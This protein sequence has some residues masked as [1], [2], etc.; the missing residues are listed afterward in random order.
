MNNAPIGIL[1]SGVG[2]LTVWREI[3]K[4]LPFESTFYIGDSANSLYGSKSRDQI[5]E[6]ASKMINF[7]VQKDVKLIVIACNTITV[8]CLDQLRLEFPHMPLI[9][10]VPVVKT[11]S[12]KTKNGKIGILSTTATAQS[13]YQK[14]LMKRFASGC[15]VLNIGTDELVPIIEQRAKIKNQKVRNV[16][17]RV[18]EPFMKA[19]IDVLALGCTHFP[20]LRPYM[21]EILG[22]GVL[23]LDSGAAI[24]RQVERVLENSHALHYQTTPEHAFFTSGDKGRLYTIIDGMFETKR[25]Q[26]PIVIQRI[27]L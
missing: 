20:F 18:L 1:D 14:D 16:L 9:G 24:A 3:V 12:E 19:E 5:F 10:T 22:K 4:K 6:L 15:E 21:Q 17:E 13:Q 25:T 26:K 2:G 27:T 23:I 8:T 11:A 7:L